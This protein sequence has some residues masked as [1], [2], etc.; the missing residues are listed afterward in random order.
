[1]TI[2]PLLGHVPYSS[3]FSCDAQRAVTIGVLYHDPIYYQFTGITMGRTK[4]CYTTLMLIILYLPPIFTFTRSIEGGS[5]HSRK[6]EV[7]FL[8]LP[9]RQSY[10]PAVAQLDGIALWLESRMLPK[11]LA[12]GTVDRV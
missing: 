4:I 6:S 5:G 3:P 9:R 11:V 2:E 8:S 1:M 12:G 7:L 10:T